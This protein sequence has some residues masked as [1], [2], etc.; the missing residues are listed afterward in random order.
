PGAAS[1]LAFTQQPTDAQAAVAISPTITVT[2]L[3]AFGN[4]VAGS[5]AS[6]TLAIGTNPSN[7]T[8]SGTTTVPPVNGVATFSGVSVDR[9]GAGYTL[10]VSSTGL[11][12]ATSTTFTISAGP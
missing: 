6:I 5:T 3:D 9:A 2:V 4:T 12:S 8:L 1:S 10:A 7:G 11:S